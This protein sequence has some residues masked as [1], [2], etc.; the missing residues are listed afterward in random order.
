MKTKKLELSQKELKLILS[1]LYVRFDEATESQ[2]TLVGRLTSRLYD[3]KDEL[4]IYKSV[5]KTK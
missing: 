5:F 3:A 2:D 1:A 4:S